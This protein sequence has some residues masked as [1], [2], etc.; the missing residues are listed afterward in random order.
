MPEIFLA[1]KY[2]TREGLENDIKVKVGIDIAKNKEGGHIIKGSHKDFKRLRLSE[3]TTIYGVK[4][5]KTGA[6]K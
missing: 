5:Q 1:K 6:K 2:K 3:T 4:C